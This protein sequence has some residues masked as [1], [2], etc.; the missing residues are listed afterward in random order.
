VAAGKAVKADHVEAETCPKFT[1]RCEGEMEP[2]AR[3]TI[4]IRRDQHLKNGF[5]I[6]GAA[7]S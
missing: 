2:P 7:R 1:H 5:K 6:S 3:E 4:M